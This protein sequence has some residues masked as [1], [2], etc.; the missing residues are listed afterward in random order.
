MRRKKFLDKETA[1]CLAAMEKLLAMLEAEAAEAGSL[2]G[3]HGLKHTFLQTVE[4]RLRAACDDLLRLGPEP[5]TLAERQARLQQLRAEA[6][7]LVREYREAY[8]Q[9][10]QPLRTS[11]RQWRRPATIALVA[12]VIGLSLHLAGLPLDGP[13]AALLTAVAACLSLNHFRFHAV[14]GHARDYLA[15]RRSQRDVRRLEKQV[16]QVRAETEAELT[17]RDW[18]ERWIEG[19]GSVVENLYRM[20]RERGEKAAGLAVLPD[21]A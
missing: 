11:G 2:D 19:R 4:P 15:Y 3:L 7:R 12:I 18:V 9:P 17:R 21:V 14:V 16:R 5:A 8:E 1:R 10:P 13:R 6:E 20:H